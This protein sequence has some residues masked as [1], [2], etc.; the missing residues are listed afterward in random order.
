MKTLLLVRGLPGSG[1]TTF[2]ET[3]V[4]KDNV[5]SADDFFTDSEGGYY[6]NPS[7]IQEAHLFCLGNVKQR[8][9]HDTD[10]AFTSTIAVANTFTQEWEMEKYYIIAKQYGYTVHTIVV[11]NR[12]GG[13]NVHDVP[14]EKIETMRNRFEI[15]L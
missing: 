10:N 15:K 8:M 14:D 12:H 5:Y 3:L 4:G 9:I 13:K 11:E 2:A 1:K 7:R 6:Y